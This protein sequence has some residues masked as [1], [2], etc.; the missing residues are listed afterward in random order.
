MNVSTRSKRK[1]LTALAGL[2]L[3]VAFGPGRVARAD[4][5]STADLSKIFG[6]WDQWE[7]AY[8]DLVSALDAFEGLT[9]E[10]IETGAPVQ[11]VST[12]TL[13]S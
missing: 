6:S 7:S 12:G 10:P 5:H 2:L 9:D 4:E 1:L 8:G 13:A 11:P 3:A